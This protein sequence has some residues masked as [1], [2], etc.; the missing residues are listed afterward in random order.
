MYREAK[1]K[2]S[3]DPIERLLIQNQTEN[4]ALTHRSTK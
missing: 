2:I 3:E 4:K 1:I